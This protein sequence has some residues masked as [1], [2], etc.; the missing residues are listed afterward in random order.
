MGE[1][2]AEYVAQQF[3]KLGVR[4]KLSPGEYGA[5]LAAMRDKKSYDL[6]MI[7]W[8]GG[9]RF[10]VGDTM[11]FQL[12][13]QS[14]FSWFGNKEFDGLLDRARE[15]M[16]S[17]G[18]QGPVRESAGARMITARRGASRPPDELDLR[19]AQDVVWESAD[20]RD[21]PAPRGGAER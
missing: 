14:P 9:G 16:R 1:A 5:W 18:A 3:G 21:D 20:R 6:G 2:V 10:D 19:G 12:H 13:S 15:T 8:G 17:R 4:V 7:G 11:F